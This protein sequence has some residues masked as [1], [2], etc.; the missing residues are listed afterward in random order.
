MQPGIDAQR[1]AE[2]SVPD[3]ETLCRLFLHPQLDAEQRFAVMRIAF[4]G[5]TDAYDFHM[6][7]LT[8]EFLEDYLRV[9]GF[10]SI[11]RVEKHGL[12]DDSS[13]L[14]IGGVPISLMSSRQNLR[15]EYDVQPVFIFAASFKAQISDG[16]RPAG[17]ST[18]PLAEVCVRIPRRRCGCRYRDRTE[19][20]RFRCDRDDTSLW[21]CRRATPTDVELFGRAYSAPIGISPIGGPGT[22]FPG[23]EKYFAAAAQAANIPYTLGVLSAITIEEAASWRRMCSGFSYTGFPETNTGSAWTLSGAPKKQM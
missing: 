7:G 9:A 3:F 1:S 5:Q 2:I 21:K 6:V 8:I 12:F 20:G 15:T 23:A 11:E 14:D 4:G 19:L 10:T 16:A 22:G 17:Q 13:T 18:S